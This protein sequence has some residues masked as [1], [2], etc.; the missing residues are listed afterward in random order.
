MRAVDQVMFGAMS[1]IHYDRNTSEHPC[2]H[3][4]VVHQVIV[5]MQDIRSV[6]SQLRGHLPNRSRLRPRLL[7]KGAHAYTI[8]GGNL[9]KLTCV[10]E[11]IDERLMAL[12]LLALR[13]VKYQPFHPADIQTCDKLYDPHEFHQP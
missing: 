7:L 5:G 8:V 12:Q 13:Q 10:S 4:V 1:R 9:A 11:A 6:M 3:S 2:S